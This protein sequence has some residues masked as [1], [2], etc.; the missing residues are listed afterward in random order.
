MNLIYSF[1]LI[2]VIYLGYLLIWFVI[3]LLAYC[4]SL[5]LKR[6]AIL[7]FLVGSAA[8]LYYIFSFLLGLYLLWVIISLLL[9]GQ[10]FW[11][12]AM[13]FIG[14]SIIYTIIGF[15]QLPFIFIPAYFLEKLENT[16]FKDGVI[17]G[18]I[19]DDKK[20]VIAVSESETAVDRR[21]AIWFITS[22]SLNLFSLIIN[23]NE[24]P[25]YKW[26][27][28][29][30][31]PFLWMLSQI[32]FFGLIVGIYYKVRKGKF[33]FNS[34]RYFLGSALKLNSIIY[35]ILTILFFLGGVWRIQ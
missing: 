26:G 24:Y 18:E 10:I 25:S 34:K 5:A 29:I 22:Y 21:V 30:S 4:L 16:I 3:N 2:L 12:I 6:P 11:F 9:S 7:T 15:L 27:D 31:T 17:K 32:L 1:V 13:I 23:R 35:I 8:V 33:F 14:M 19:L 20:H 28:F